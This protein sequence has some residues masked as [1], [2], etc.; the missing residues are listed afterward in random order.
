MTNRKSVFCLFLA[1]LV[2]CGV[3]A[4]CAADG[5]ESPSGAPVCVDLYLPS[6]PEV[7]SWEAVFGDE[8]I[9]A[10]DWA[11]YPD[12]H[13]L[14]LIGTSGAE[15]FRLRGL[16]PGTTDVRFQF[17]NSFTL[18]T[19][20]TLVWR[21]TVDEELNVSTWGF[22]MLE[23]ETAPRGEIASFFFTWGGYN[24]PVTLTLRR[25]GDG[26]LL[27]DG[28][29]QGEIPVQEDFLASLTELV[30]R[31]NVP[32]WNGFRSTPGSDPEALMILDGENFSLSVVYENGFAVEASG[33]N[34][35]PENYHEFQSDAAALFLGDDWY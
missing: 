6:D 25:D 29:P 20:L 9:A 8:A 35:F 2:L 22:E 30:N 32:S 19:D 23:P 14:G 28:G 17:V 27:A 18:H 12:I 34:D 7:G 31:W 16:A 5:S 26:T 13:E 10:A 15:W 3:S 1:F 4:S 11:F 24:A 21:I 33:D